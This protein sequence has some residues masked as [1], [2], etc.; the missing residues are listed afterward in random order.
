MSDAITLASRPA[1]VP[2]ECF[3]DFD[4]YDPPGAAED[5]FAS[6]KTLWR[7]G[8]PAI[9][10]TPHNGGHWIATR[11]EDI[12]RFM[13]DAE[14]FSSHV[15]TVPPEIGRATQFIPVQSDPP[16]HA[17]YR[18]A[19]MRGFA[20]K[21]ILAL[22]GP[23]RA[24]M[25]EL[26]DEL[27][28]RGGCEFVSEF[29]EVL[30]INAFLTLAGL[31]TSDRAMLRELGAYLARPDGTLT[32]DDMVR[33]ADEYLAPYVRARM[34]EPGEDLFS[35][36]LARPLDGRP[37]SEDEAQRMCRNLLFGGLDT[38]A[39]MIAF[40]TWHLARH[41]DQQAQLRDDPRLIGAATDEFLRAF[42]SASVG[43]L[44]TRD[45]DVDGITMKAGDIVHLP[46]MLHNQDERSF[47]QADA[48]LFDR[49]LTKHSTM[50]NGPHRCVGAALARLEVMLF[51]ERW[52]ARVPAFRIDSDAPVTMKGGGI[53]TLTALPVR[54][55]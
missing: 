35:R 7:D 15:L 17:A 12:H 1:H 30:P 19:V 50:G 37:W 34:A 6:W 27:L 54:W 10:W 55:N 23:I 2:A 42:G 4:I 49:G 18:S 44:L 9:V 31:P 45:V 26:I 13:G 32:P 51:L 25:D 53:G 47:P 21:S 24:L 3:V 20:S 29:A 5:F 16:M 28:P 48:I 33:M 41:P 22:E 52:L 11:G 8:L 39:A 38:V 43:R 40:V 36:I 46:S 14:T